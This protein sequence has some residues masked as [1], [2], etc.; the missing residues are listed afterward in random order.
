MSDSKVIAGQGRALIMAATRAVR[1][2]DDTHRAL[3]P[4]PG[5]KTAGWLVGHLAVTG[6][7]G[8]RLCNKPPLCPREW[9]NTFN[10][11]STPSTNA[12]D[13]PPMSLLRE[14]MLAV[15]NDLCAAFPTVDVATFAVPNPYTP[16]IGE[17]PTAGDFA[18]YL[19]TGHLAYHLGQ[20]TAWRAAAG[21]PIAHVSM[22]QPAPA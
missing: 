6:D 18:A 12:G 1:D 21:L 13:Y 11:G 16:S 8:R 5:L 15:Y 7:F 3:E 17:Y 14:T 9:R 4:A 22:S 2:L 10:P 20:L 19:L